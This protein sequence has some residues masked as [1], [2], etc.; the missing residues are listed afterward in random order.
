MKR[1]A[2][3]VAFALGANYF[4]FSSPLAQNTPVVETPPKGA[5]SSK[6]TSG[7]IPKLPVALEGLFV[8]RNSATF[9]QQSNKME[10]Q[11]L[12]QGTDGKVTG[13]FTRWLQFPGSPEGLCNRADKLPME[14]NYD[15]EKLVITVSA[16]KNS[17]LC[18]DFTW[19]FLRGREHY[20]ERKAT[21]GNWYIYYDVAN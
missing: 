7:G 17:P 15:G 14:G 10:L 13:T 19:T 4:L 9:K 11:I 20:L 1:M 6:D 12:T 5:E 18:Q 2:S 8:M 3:L 16:S 21:D